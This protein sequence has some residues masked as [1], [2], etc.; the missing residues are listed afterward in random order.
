MS[1]ATRSAWLP[2][3]AAMTAAILAGGLGTRLRPAGLDRPK[4]LAPVG[5]RPF[6]TWILDWL[7]RSGVERVVLCTGVGASALEQTL[8]ES[9]G[10][11]DLVHSPEP[12]PLGTGGALRH[13]LEHLPRGPVLVL[14]GDTFCP[15]DLHGLWSA[16]LLHPAHATLAVHAVAEASDYG[17]VT[18]DRGGMVLDFREKDGRPKPALVNVGVCVVEQALLERIPPDRACS[19]ER[20]LLP[21]WIRR[22]HVFAWHSEMP[23]HDIGTP[24]RWRAAAEF[25]RGQAR[26]VETEHAVPDES[27][28]SA[29]SRPAGELP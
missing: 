6:V 27:D 29:G 20:E 23:V 25:I 12:H 28:P 4:V 2:R 3:P 10:P 26:S 16:H 18:V 5:G 13:A 1:A 11:L 22:H 24:E 7:A 19:L 15:L 9:H 21:E 8:G 14:N 17:S